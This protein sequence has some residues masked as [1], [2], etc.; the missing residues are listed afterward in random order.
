[1]GIESRIYMG[2]VGPLVGIEREDCIQGFGR[3]RHERVSC[4]ELVCWHVERIWAWCSIHGFECCGRFVRKTGSN[5][6]ML[7]LISIVA[8]HGPLG[9]AGEERCGRV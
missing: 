5:S 1:M 2:I 3:R 9:R 7:L 4:F 6:T 8:H